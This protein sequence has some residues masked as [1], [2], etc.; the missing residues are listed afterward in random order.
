MASKKYQGPYSAV[1]AFPAGWEVEEWEVVMIGT[2]N[3]ETVHTHISPRTYKQR[4]AAVRRATTLNK[5]W[6]KKH[7]A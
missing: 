1:P 7:P 5:Q 4:T 6:L 2:V 3:E